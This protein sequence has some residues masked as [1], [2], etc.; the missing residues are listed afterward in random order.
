MSKE[1]YEDLSTLPYFSK[2]GHLIP[3]HPELPPEARAQLPLLYILRKE[4]KH[5]PA[6]EPASGTPWYPQIQ[7]EATP[8]IDEDQR[9]KTKLHSQYNHQDASGTP[10]HC[11]ARPCRR[12][13]ARGVSKPSKCL[14]NDRNRITRAPPDQV[15]S[16]RLA[17]STK[18]RCT[19]PSFEKTHER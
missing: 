8:T 9:P 17:L 2:H 6:E 11:G 13:D 10:G 1:D 4:Q 5:K 7:W 18:Q 12:R 16:E 3:D 14:Q 19:S 15:R